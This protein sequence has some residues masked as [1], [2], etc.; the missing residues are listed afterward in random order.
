M[1]AEPAIPGL[2][3]VRLV[4]AIDTPMN[5]GCGE[6]FDTQCLPNGDGSTLVVEA[7]DG[8]RG[9]RLTLHVALQAVVRGVEHSSV[10]DRT[11]QLDV[12]CVSPH[13]RHRGTRG[14][15][16][17]ELPLRKVWSVP[18]L[19]G[20]QATAGSERL[21]GVEKASRLFGSP[22]CQFVVGA[23]A[24]EEGPGAPYA[25]TI[26]RC[27]VG[28]LPIAVTIVSVPGWSLGCLNAQQR[29]D[30]LDGVHDA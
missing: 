18:D 23:L 9:P 19:L 4:P 17:E 8:K 29:V 12:L 27:P 15:T 22:R 7:P 10:A 28:V 2:G 14:T 20:E 3:I 16:G 25:H 1:D 5:D 26:E 21:D 24:D 11:E 30:R 13:Q 6:R